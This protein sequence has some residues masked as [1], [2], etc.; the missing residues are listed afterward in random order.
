M[1][2]RLPKIDREGN[3]IFIGHYYLM[4]EPIALLGE[5]GESGGSFG[6]GDGR[7]LHSKEG[8]MGRMVIGFDQPRWWRMLDVLNHEAIEMCCSR[9]GV[10]YQ[11][12]DNLNVTTAGYYFLMNHEEFAEA[13]MQASKFTSAAQNDLAR[14]WK[15]TK[16]LKPVSA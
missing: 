12:A 3:Y 8:L 2:K 6:S 5:I 7:P 1:K 15:R 9:M 16:Y 10:R 11:K 14:M 4:K 13:I